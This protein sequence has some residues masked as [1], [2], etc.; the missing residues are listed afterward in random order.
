[1]NHIDL[2]IRADVE[3]VTVTTTTAII[4]GLGIKPVL[5]GVKAGFEPGLAV[6]EN[7]SEPKETDADEEADAE[8]HP[9]G[10]IETGVDVATRIDIPDD[11]ITP[12]AME[13]LG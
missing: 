2:D 5:E 12:D 6:V 1:M 4:D 3:A 13:Q 7:E 10:T 9:E 8:S 11:L